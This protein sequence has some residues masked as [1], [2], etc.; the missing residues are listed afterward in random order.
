M[1]GLL[2]AIEGADASGKHTQAKLLFE[3]L[4]KEGFSGAMVSFPRYEEFWGKLVKKY[5]RGE[6]GSL[7]EVKPEFA[8]LLYSLDRLDAM[9]WIEQELGK[10]KIVVCD[11]YIASNV[12]HQAAKFEGKGR[13]EFIRWLEAVE[14]RLPQPD[15]TI[16]LDLPVSVSANLMKGRAREKDIHELDLKYLEAVRGV[17]LSLSK[18][19]GWFTIDCFSGKGIRPK[20]EIHGLLW[21]KLREYL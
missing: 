15:L 7:Q 3:R 21:Q 11:R 13:Q 14:S 16:F 19:P 9:P 10:G 1:K 5:L 8:S 12:A 20:E 6:F 4:K 18:R 17:Y 2:I